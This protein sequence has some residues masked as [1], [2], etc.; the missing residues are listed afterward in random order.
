[1]ETTDAVNAL[2]ALAQNH[3]LAVF[4]LLVAAGQDGLSAGDIAARLGVA[5]NTLTFHLDR[6][7]HAALVTVR[8]DGRSMIYAARFDAMKDLLGF[9][10]DDCCGG[11]PDICQMTR[12]AAQR[13]RKAK[14][15]D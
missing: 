3:R 15:C 7:R 4:R 6:L 1:M 13:S 9:L 12:P 14:I 8:R 10:T 5:P 11:Q 2:A